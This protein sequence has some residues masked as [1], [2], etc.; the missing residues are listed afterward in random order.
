MIDRDSFVG[1]LFTDERIED[2]ICY[3]I[4]E[5]C[6]PNDDDERLTL[7]SD[8]FLTILENSSNN[9]ALKVKSPVSKRTSTFGE[10]R[11]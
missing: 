10:I 1:N 7:N 2:I 5:Q 8:M 3:D 4:W 11:D 9:K 6:F